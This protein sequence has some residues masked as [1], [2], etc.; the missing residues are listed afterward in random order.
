MYVKQG[1]P[2]QSKPML[3]LYDC[4]KES[5]YTIEEILKDKGCGFD[6]VAILK[7]E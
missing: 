5:P 6:Q 4:K 2:D 1:A 3:D 7:V